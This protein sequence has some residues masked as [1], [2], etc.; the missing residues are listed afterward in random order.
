MEQYQYKPLSTGEDR[1]VRIRLLWLLPGELHQAVV[2]RIRHVVF[3]EAPQYEALSYCWGHPSV[4]ARVSIDQENAVS[5]MNVTENLFTALRHLRKLTVPRVLWVDAM[6]ID[7]SN[8]SEKS[9]QIRLMRQIYQTAKTVVVWLG[10]AADNS[11]TAL[12]LIHLINYAEDR[13]S[14]LGIRSNLLDLDDDHWGLPRTTDD[15]WLDLFKVL[16]RPWFRRAWVVQEV[17]V[18]RKAIMICGTFTAD[19]TDFMRAF[20]YTITAG[21]LGAT[22]GLA[23]LN[24]VMLLEFTR[25]KFSEKAEQ[26]PLQ[27]LLRHRS[28]LASEPKDHV[29]AFHGLFTQSDNAISIDDLDYDLD[30]VQ[31]YKRL[32][33]KAILHDK[34][35]D[36]LS[37]PRGQDSSTIPNLPTWVP[38]WSAS[39]IC[40]SLLWR[41]S[42][43]GFESNLQPKHRASGASNYVPVFDEDHSKLKL[44]GY[45][46]DRIILASMVMEAALEYI[47]FD[48]DEGA[49]ASI[50]DQKILESW[51]FVARVRLPWTKYPTGEKI[52]D[53]Y[54]QTLLAGV[55]PSLYNVM[56]TIFLKWDRTVIWFRVMQVLR[57]D[58][59]WFLKLMI[60]MMAYISI[61]A[62]L[63]GYNLLPK[64]RQVEI[65]P[66]KLIATAMGHRRMI[67][68]AAG[69][70]GLAPRLAKEGDHIAICKG[71]KVPL[72]LRPKD[73]KTWELIGDSYIHGVMDGWA[74]E[75]LEGSEFKESE[76]RDL[77]LT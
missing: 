75:L 32:A 6:C 62:Q 23:D 30:C 76:F 1:R 60:L 67:R 49:K 4:M 16:K 52:M 26:T 7:Q 20:Q 77:W 59:V 25:R 40:E 22:M 69:F 72:V 54:W 10:E 71:G 24:Q 66:F 2:C 21:G 46:F 64:S 44:E 61:I 14:A 28:S 5:H 11:D 63:F 55:D 8:T 45:L 42:E 68:T 17:A 48:A 19:W 38:D 56:R 53:V 27:V 58:R 37:V 33:V 9:L 57:L 39:T 51:E 3:A 35:L 50:Q 43:E 18:A 47:A 15:L 65:Y 13:D 41:T 74:W 29:F 36:I 34:S 70:I 73:E 12:P 31:V